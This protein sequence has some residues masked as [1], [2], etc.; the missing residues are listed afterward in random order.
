MKSILITGGSG[1]LGSNLCKRLL[2][3]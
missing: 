1:F 2:G 3:G